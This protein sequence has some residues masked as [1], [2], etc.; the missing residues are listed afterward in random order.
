MAFDGHGTHDAHFVSTLM[1]VHRERPGW[2]AVRRCPDEVVVRLVPAGKRRRRGR[3][4]RH[5]MVRRIGRCH[6]ELRE[7]RESQLLPAQL[8]GFPGQIGFGRA[9]VRIAHSVS[10]EEEDVLGC[11]VLLVLPPVRAEGAVTDQQGHQD[12]E[13]DGDGPE[14]CLQFLV[15]HTAKITK[16]QPLRGCFL[17][18]IVRINLRLF[19]KRT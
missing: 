6:R 7:L 13:P 19:S 9:H 3:R 14:G 16:K 4:A 15:F 18:I 17:A 11:R 5:L 12:Q 2:Q 10:D 8:S 1:Q